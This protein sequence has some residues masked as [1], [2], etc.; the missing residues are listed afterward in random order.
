MLIGI[1]LS[2]ACVCFD[3]GSVECNHTQLKESSLLAELENLYELPT[4]SSDVNPSEIT[5]D[6]EIWKISTPIKSSS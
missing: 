6:S 2:Y 3:L 4:K 1:T 5:Q